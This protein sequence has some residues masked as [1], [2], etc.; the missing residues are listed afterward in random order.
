MLI[1]LIFVMLAAERRA[2]MGM[3]RAVG[4]KR[5]H[6]IQQFLFEGYAY[7]LGAAL[8]GIVLGMGVGL[9]MVAVHGHRCWAPADFTICR[10]TSSRAAW[11][12]PSAWARWSPSSP[13]SFSSWRVSRLNIVAAIRDLPEDFGETTFRWRMPGSGPSATSWSTPRRHTIR[14]VLTLRSRWC[15]G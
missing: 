5:R 11:W 2:E 12:W 15:W 8:V 9:G 6:L 10:A 3:A 13:W 7:N 14:F 4:T 1:F